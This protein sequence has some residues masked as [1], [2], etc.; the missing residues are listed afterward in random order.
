MHQTEEEL[1]VLAAQ[2]GSDRAFSL[3]FHRYQKALL[4]YG[5]KV[6]GDGEIAQDA[7]QDAWLKLAKN[8]RRLD[9][10]RAFKSWIY[11]L[12]HWSCIDLLR[13]TK[14]SKLYQDL[15]DDIVVT[16]DRAN[17]QD[18]LLSVAISRLPGPEK[19]MIHLVYLEELSVKEVAKVLKISEGT[20]KSRLNRAR[21]LL[22]ER[23][24]L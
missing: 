17:E 11:Q 4:R 22:K 20:V 2:D 1:L 8:I 15:S 14:H 5:F 18:D 23:F 19:Q 10:P 3:L 9:D 6:S 7:V 24:Y 12:V 21:R 13:A 16:S